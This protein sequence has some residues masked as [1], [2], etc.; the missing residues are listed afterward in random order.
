MKH[1]RLGKPKL[2]LFRL[3]DSGTHIY[4]RSDRNK[5]QVRSIALQSVKQVKGNSC[6]GLRHNRLLNSQPALTLRMLSFQMPFLFDPREVSQWR[7]GQV[8]QV[9]LMHKI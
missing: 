6:M 9:A 2:H 4:W 5:N 7:Q 1:G 3:Q 8:I